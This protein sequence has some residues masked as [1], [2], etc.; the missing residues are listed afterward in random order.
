MSR[1]PRLFGIGCAMIAVSGLTAANSGPLEATK[2]ELRKLDRE[3]RPNEGPSATE[4]LRPNL[5]AI[6]APGPDALPTMQPADPDKVEK[7]R[8]RRKDAQKN[9]LVN[10]VEQLE[11]SE[12]EKESAGRATAVEFEVES[13]GTETDDDPQYLLKIYDERKK[14]EAAR[15]A[16]KT[17]QRT[18]RSD[19]LAPF[20]QDWLGSSPVRGQFFDRFVRN[21]PTT[22]GGEGTSSGITPALT[23]RDPLAVNLP[24]ERGLSESE[25]RTNPYLVPPTAPALS[26]PRWNHD[27]TLNPIDPVLNVTPPGQSSI[28]PAV[29]PVDIRPPE[30]KP[31]PPP[32]ADERK[33]FPQLKKF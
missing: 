1:F 4:G 12:I 15:K 6:Q 13:T 24:A 8:K 19:P 2:Q 21:D 30:R 3:Q 16:E 5:P 10:G 20:L 33:Y 29:A 31:P 17:A 9:W 27:L 28:T 32:L 14:G 26:E 18:P 23:N 22:P 25:P 11:K 7:E